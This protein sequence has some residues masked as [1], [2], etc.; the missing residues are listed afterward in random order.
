MQVVD[1]EGDPRKHREGARKKGCVDEQVIAVGNWA[2][3]C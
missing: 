1:L 2:P 3:S